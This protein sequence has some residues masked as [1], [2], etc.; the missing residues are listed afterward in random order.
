[1]HCQVPGER[2]QS[3]LIHGTKVGSREGN[4]GAHLLRLPGNPPAA[5]LNA[6][7]IGSY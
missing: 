4:L 1:M 6:H 3:L 2:P 7:G 5:V